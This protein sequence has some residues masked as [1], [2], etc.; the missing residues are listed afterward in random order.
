[1]TNGEDTK[2][3]AKRSKDLFSAIYAVKPA[4]YSLALV[5]AGQAV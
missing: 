4:E 1:V 3:S 5:E 2:N